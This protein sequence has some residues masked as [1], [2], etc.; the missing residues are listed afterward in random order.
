MKEGLYIPA[1]EMGVLLP[2]PENIFGKGC[3]Q[4]RIPAGV[5]NLLVAVSYVLSSCAGG[6]FDS[7]TQNEFD[8]LQVKPTATKTSN[9]TAEKIYIPPSPSSELQPE[10]GEYEPRQVMISPLGENPIFN[11]IDPE[12][13]NIFKC[14]AVQP[15]STRS[16]EVS[17]ETQG[18]GEQ[19]PVNLEDIKGVKTFNTTVKDTS[20]SRTP[21]DQVMALIVKYCGLQK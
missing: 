21:I 4:E 18:I 17:C 5:L 16:V 2:D 3:I 15:K 14:T 20:L 10:C 7:H 1:P 19:T 8:K 13:G 9:G 12:T 11:P 6:A